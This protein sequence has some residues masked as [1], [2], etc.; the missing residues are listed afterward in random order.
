MSRQIE[1]CGTHAD[2][3]LLPELLSVDRC[4]RAPAPVKMVATRIAV[5]F[6]NSVTQLVETAE[7]AKQA[8][9]RG[10][11]HRRKTYGC[12]AASCGYAHDAAYAQLGTMLRYRPTEHDKPWVAGRSAP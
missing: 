1:D 7:F 6:S 5:D 9:P 2:C 4:E 8:S 3:L 10:G 12:F 11:F